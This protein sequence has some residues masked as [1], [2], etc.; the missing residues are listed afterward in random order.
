MDKETGYSAE[1]ELSMRNAQLG[2]WNEMFFDMFDINGDCDPVYVVRKELQSLRTKLDERDKQLS[3]LGETINKLV[4][5]NEELADQTVDYQFRISELE[6][7]NK[8]LKIEL[9]HHEAGNSKLHFGPK[10]GE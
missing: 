10:G 5:R 4:V 7:E 8:I 1:H 2:K 6:T 3:E 9:A